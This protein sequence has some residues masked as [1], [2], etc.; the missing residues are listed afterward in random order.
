MKQPP[1]VIGN[2]KMNPTTELDAQHITKAVAKSAK[3]HP[4][5]TVAIAPPAIFFGVCRKVGPALPLIAQT[6]YHE[7]LGAF[8]GEISPLMVK[9]SGGIGVI[10]GHSERRALGETDGQV[11][12]KCDAALKHGLTPIVC[13]GEKDRD[14]QGNFF[15]HIEAQI[16]SIFTGQ[17]V[18]AWKKIVLAYEPIWAIGTGK[19]ATP[20]DVVEMQLFIRKVLT[21]LSNRA[22]A[23]HTRV[24]YGGSVNGENAQSLYATGV[25]QGF[26]VGGASLRPAEFEL[27]IKAVADQTID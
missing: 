12:T 22:T 19:T 23:K 1:L 2:W 17:P 10:I 26:L 5:V 6:M 14:S 4:T 7:A 21:G 27:I 11:R 8:T 24:L 3:R 13:I 25:I 20:E 16:H 15:L 9:N 18:S